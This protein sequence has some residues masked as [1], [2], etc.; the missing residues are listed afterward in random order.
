MAAPC[1]STQDI[2]QASSSDQTQV[3]QEI[4]S[5]EEPRNSA[6]KMLPLPNPRPGSMPWPLPNFLPHWPPPQPPRGHTNPPFTQ[7]HHRCT[8]AGCRGPHS[9]RLSALRAHVSTAQATHATSKQAATVESN[10][11]ATATLFAHWPTPVR[12][13][14]V[15]PGR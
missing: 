2:P 11:Q 6:S 5:A 7:R 10:L 13:C 15:A 12:L 9:P 4:K 1:A 3:A 14:P 8:C